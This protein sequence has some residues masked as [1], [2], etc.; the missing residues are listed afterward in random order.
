M[1][2]KVFN[3]IKRKKHMVHIFK[4]NAQFFQSGVYVFDDSLRFI[5]LKDGT[6]K[7]I[8]FEL[9]HDKNYFSKTIYKWIVHLIKR[10]Y[11]NRHMVI[12]N[13]RQNNNCFL[14]TVFFIGINQCNTAKAFDFS[15]KQVL[16]F[17]FSEKKYVQLIE[18]HHY[19]SQFFK[20][21]KI[22]SR[23]SERL[24]F[25][26][27]LVE[28]KTNNKWSEEDSLFVIDDMFKCYINYFK[29]CKDNGSYYLKKPSSI[30]KILDKEDEVIAFIHHTTE[31]KVL[32]ESFPFLKMHGDL[33]APNILLRKSNKYDINYIDFEY[34][35]DLLLV[36]DVFWFIQS[37][38]INNNHFYLEKYISGAFDHYFRE[39]FKIFDLTFE[40]KYR[41][42]YLNI[43]F[44]N[45]YENRWRQ[46]S[47][48][49]KHMKLRN[50]KNMLKKYKSA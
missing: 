35:N 43:F 21:P 1:F 3:F 4:E 29:K 9:F 19:F 30:L 26:E 50:Y 27:E 7:E 16:T 45:V 42:D 15:N 18:N 2:K 47:N 14:G 44:M 34:S 13:E 5:Y 20:T 12:K 38:V 49:A 48:K 33:W 41:Y 24:L 8:M 36:Y 22:L 40:E 11:F 10:V 25:I 32:N 6:N 37:Q 28:Y 39:M 31:R 23:D 17:S 46:L